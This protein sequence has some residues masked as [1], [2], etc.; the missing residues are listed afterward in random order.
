MAQVYYCGRQGYFQIE[1]STYPMQNWELSSEVTYP[2]ISNWAAVAA[3]GPIQ[4]F[5]PN[6]VGGTITAEG[7]LSNAG[8]PS[9]T[10]VPPVQFPTA[11]SYAEFTL[12][13][14]TVPALA[15]TVNALIVNITPSQD[16]TDAG[17]FT[18]EAVIS[19]NPADLT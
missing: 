6:L 16:I 2:E 18:I 3:G 4:M 13:V 10:L 8:V 14:G 7:F 12:G 17:R 5:C 1:G 19:L 9:S 11:G 15:Y